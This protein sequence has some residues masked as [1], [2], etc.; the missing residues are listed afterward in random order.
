MDQSVDT[1]PSLLLNWHEPEE[2]SRWVR[3][4]IGTVVVHVIFF[5]IFTFLASLD[6][7]KLLEE[8]EPVA[9]KYTPIYAPPFR[10]TQ[11]EPT[12]AKVPKEVH[13]E[14]LLPKPAIQAR[15]PTPPVA[16]RTFQAPSSS[17]APS[18]K[19]VPLPPAPEPPKY[20][21]SVKPPQVLPPSVLAVPPPQQTQP[22]PEERPKLTFETPGQSGSSATPGGTPKVPIPKPSVDDA[23]RSV[24]RSG[25]SMG[26]GMSV[27]DIDQFP[28]PPDGLRR[29]PVA[30]RMQSSVQLQ[31]DPMGVDFKPYLIRV[32]ATV[33][34]N[35]FAVYPESARLGLRG[36]V[37]LRFW[38]DRNG[39]VPH[40]ELAMPSGATAL[41]RAAV[42]SIS[43]SV[44]LPPLPAEFKGKQI[45]L[46]FS[47]QYN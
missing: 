25:G 3:A 21:A 44:P 11:K 34:R 35:W 26:S 8:K 4:G 17:P 16:K 33:K 41:D 5:G 47:F 24:V 14:D 30:G 9:R 27:S 37:A 19:P 31:S 22:P 7:P 43:A 1:G 42:A 10:L 45:V 2:N 23:I 39:Q 13:L 36:S 20:E 46:Q 32:L 28:S 38:V 6:T 15:T 12:N 29:N 40:L 18:P